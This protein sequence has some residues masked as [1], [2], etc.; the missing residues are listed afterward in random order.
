MCSC[1]SP[2]TESSIV[3]LCNSPLHCAR[4]SGSP[5]GYFALPQAVVAMATAR[6]CAI[7]LMPFTRGVQA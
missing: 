3:A 2:Q 6:R 7:R 5:L 4:A 1:V